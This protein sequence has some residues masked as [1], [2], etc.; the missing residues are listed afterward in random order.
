M[1]TKIL[2]Q[3]WSGQIACEVW[4]SGLDIKDFY[5]LSFVTVGEVHIFYFYLS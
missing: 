3:E 5:Q 2:A 4:I 1:N